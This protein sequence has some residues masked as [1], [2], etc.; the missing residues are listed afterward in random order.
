MTKVTVNNKEYEFESLSDTA[1]SN[2]VSLK[3]VQEELKRLEAQTA[4]YKT[5]EL[6]YSRVL[7]KELEE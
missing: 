4:V 1:K 2:L 7:T 5:S 6:A 3:F